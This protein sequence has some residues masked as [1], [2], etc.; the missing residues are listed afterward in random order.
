M[1]WLREIKEDLFDIAHRLRE[2]DSRYRVYRNLKL[3]RFEIHAN[4]VLQ[5][6]APFDSLDART[7]ELVRSTR[8][9]NADRLIKDMEVR[10]GELKRARENA[11]RER[12]LTEVEKVI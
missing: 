8:V 7:L 9:E 4:G 12:I 11:A 6:A 5:L 10:N 3:N 1:D 2:I